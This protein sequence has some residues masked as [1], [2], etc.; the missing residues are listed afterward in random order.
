MKKYNF[1]GIL[2]FLLIGF[3]AVSAQ[4][5]PFKTI[6]G[7]VLNGKSISLPKPEYTEAMS[8]AGIEGTVQISVLI[9]ENGN[10]ISAEPVVDDKSKIVSDPKPNSGDVENYKV[11]KPEP[12]NPLLVD[13]ARNAAMKANFSPTTLSGVPVRVT[14]IIVY[15]F[16]SSR[17]ESNNNPKTIDGGVI[18]GKA[19]SLPLP[20]YPAA[21]RAVKA[22]GAVAVQVVIDE[23]GNVISANAVSGHPLLRQAASDAAM[24]AKFSPTLLQGEAVKVSGVLMHNFVP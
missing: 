16:R 18:N 17:S 14:G 19:T 2:L 8:L 7:G 9:D 5:D 15:N 22:G 3:S 24:S 23:T 1:V 13:S 4:T 11:I 20:A 10:V 21:A 12:P 6:R